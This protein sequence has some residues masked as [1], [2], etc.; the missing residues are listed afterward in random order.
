MIQ[1]PLLDVP[2]SSLPVMPPGEVVIYLV[3]AFNVGGYWKIH[4]TSGSQEF[5]SQEKAEQFAAT[6]GK[7]WLHIRLL[8]VVLA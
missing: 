1:T 7:Q 3:A 2:V 8:R 5:Q 4:R 6:L